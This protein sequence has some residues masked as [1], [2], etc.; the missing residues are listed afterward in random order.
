M[1][2]GP[3]G[4]F[5]A[6]IDLRLATNLLDVDEQPRTLLHALKPAAPEG[7][8]VSLLP[9]GTWLFGAAPLTRTENL[10]FA[11]AAD[12]K[13]LFLDSDRD[14]RLEP[15]ERVDAL[16]RRG[17]IA[18]FATH[19]LVSQDA[20]GKT[21]QHDLAMHVGV[22]LTV[23]MSQSRLDAYRVGTLPGPTRPVR[24]AI[25]DR[26]FRGWFTHPGRDT[27]MIDVDG[28]GRFDPSP[29]SPERYKLGEPFPLEGIDAVVTAI[30][31]LGTTLTIARSPKPARRIVSVAVGAPAPLFEAKSIDGK[32]WSTEKLRGKWVLLD[33]WATWCVLDPFVFVRML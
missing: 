15:E 11:V 13:S 9:Q 18:W 27:L 20:S 6:T 23:P 30:G 10:P 16:G 7:L 22:A 5:I 28:N 29:E 21:H 17:E 4:E 19:A 25:V 12:R 3:A 31:P 8:D 26:T 33:F 32:T 24:V 1:P 14:A 2:P